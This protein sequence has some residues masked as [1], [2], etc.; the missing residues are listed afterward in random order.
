MKNR[1]KTGEN[2]MVDQYTQKVKD[3]EEG[4]TL[5]YEYIKVNGYAFRPNEKGLKELSRMLDLNV[6]YIRRLINTFL[7]A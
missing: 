7:E 4:R 1:Q 2:K 3:F 5:W 6:P